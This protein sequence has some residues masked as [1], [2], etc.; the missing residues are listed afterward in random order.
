MKAPM[1]NTSP[2]SAPWR[3]LDRFGAASRCLLRVNENCGRPPWT[4]A[5]Y[6]SRFE[7]LFPHWSE[8]P[9]ELDEEGIRQMVHELDLGEGTRIERDYPAALLAHQSGHRIL[10]R[11][12]R[13]PLQQAQ[14]DAP[15]PHTMLLER[16]SAGE[17]T[18]W[19]P[20]ESDAADVLSPAAPVWWRSWDARAIVIFPPAGVNHRLPRA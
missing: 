8:R 13:A 11:T 10:V 2:F 15:R 19:C 4:D 18:L 16:M 3:T 9:G 6:L 17:F 14:S 5:D 1:P 20:F 7:P 12:Q